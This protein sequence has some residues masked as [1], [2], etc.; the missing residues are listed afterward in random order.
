MAVFN[1]CLRHYL[2]CIRVEI[3]ASV[4]LALDCLS[5]AKLQGSREQRSGGHRAPIKTIGVPVLK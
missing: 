1:I 4:C 3:S 2:F 5:I